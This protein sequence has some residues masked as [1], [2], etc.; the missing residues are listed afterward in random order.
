MGPSRLTTAGKRSQA[1]R[2]T[3]DKVLGRLAPSNPI[4]DCSKLLFP[5]SSVDVAQHSTIAV[6]FQQIFKFTV[7]KNSEVD[8]RVLQA[9]TESQS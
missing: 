5:S 9:K 4:D 7:H 1:T 3:F 2:K 6:N 8:S